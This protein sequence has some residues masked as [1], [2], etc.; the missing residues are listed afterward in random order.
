MGD[1][2]GGVIVVSGGGRAPVAV[3][4][5]LPEGATVVAA[6]SGVDTALA[7]GLHVDIAV[8]D[9]DSVSADG[10][11]AVEAAGA[12]VIRHPEAKDATDLVL[13]LDVAAELLGDE[14]G[15]IVVIGAPAGRLDHLVAGIL[16]LAAPSLS[17][18]TV[19]ANLGEAM[20]H[21][22]HGPG[23][24]VLDAPIDATVTLLPVGGAAY[25]VRTDGLRFPLRG[26]PLDA[27]TSRGVSN[28]V[29][30]SG[31]RVEVGAGTLLVVL[32]G[33]ETLDGGRP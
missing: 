14:P 32:P 28:V 17:R 16:A 1:H 13:A 20:V 30:A 9:F 26:E 25:G 6:D 27:G 2:A 33:D 10:L 19:R 29:E 3:R 24:V 22:V 18:H 21:V 15:E 12:R 5:L 4:A 8:G 7:L 23:D 11:A 31:A